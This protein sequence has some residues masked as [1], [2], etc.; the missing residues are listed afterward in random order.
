MTELQDKLQQYA[1]LLVGVGMNVQKDQPVFIR[2]SVDALELTHYIVEAAYKR[3]ASDV[4]VEYSDDKLSRL[5]FEYESVEFFE[6]D[7]VKSYEVEKRMDY[8]KRGAANL[9]LITQDPDLLN[10]I[11]S[12]KLSTYQRQYS[13]AYKGYMEASQKNQFPWCVAAFPSKAWAQ[14]VYPD[15]TETEAY[16]KFIDEVLDIVR[17]D[18]NDPV[19]NWKNHVENLSIHARKLQDKNYKALHYISEG[20]D[21]VIGLPEGHIWE[22]ATSYTS[23]GQAFVANIPTEEVFTAPHRLNVN[24]HVTNKLPLSHNG[25][26]IDG[27]TLTFKD[28]EVVDFKADQGEDVLRDLLNTDEGARRLGEVALV[29]DDSPISNRNTIFY[30]TLFDENASCHI[31]LGSAYGF[32]VEGGTEMTTEEKLA[33]GLNDSLIHV[34]F[35]I[36]SPDLTIY[37]ITQD[38]EKELVFE[39]G[40]WSK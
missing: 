6:K 2:S 30:N 21:L 32:N 27:F 15:L 11:D 24:G 34:D 4:K 10:G 3:G 35:M 9:A 23:E 29:P 39:N 17:V 5:K 20:T 26:I 28:G 12:E 13:T 25:N 7:A 19:E 8:V 18:G 40:N 22:D 1:E 31:A 38:D 36:G 14:R 33:H 16:S 37:G